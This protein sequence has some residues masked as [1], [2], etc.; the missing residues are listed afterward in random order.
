M[1]ATLTLVTLPLGLTPTIETGV[2][3]VIGKGIAQVDSIGAGSLTGYIWNHSVGGESTFYV[4]LADVT[5][6]RIESVVSRE[7]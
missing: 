2:F 3:E 6:R 1:A 5:G 4:T 7:A